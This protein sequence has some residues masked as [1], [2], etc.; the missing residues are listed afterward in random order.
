MEGMKPDPASPCV[1]LQGLL[2]CDEE[3]PQ[4]VK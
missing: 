4:M 3:E 2:N 1:K